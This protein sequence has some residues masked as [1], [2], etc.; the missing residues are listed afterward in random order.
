MIRRLAIL[1][2]SAVTAAG[3]LPAVLMGGPNGEIRKPEIVRFL[4]A[5][6]L[7]GVLDWR[8]TGGR[9]S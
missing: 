2:L 7:A 9:S 8:V 4:P 1:S 6:Q 5:N 3:L